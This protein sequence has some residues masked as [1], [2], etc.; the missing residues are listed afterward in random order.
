MSRA[1]CGLRSIIVAP[2]LASNDLPRVR[3]RRY[4]RSPGLDPARPG[5]RREA[6]IMQNARIPHGYTNVTP[7]LVVP[8]VGRQLD[9]LRETF[10]AEV[11]VEPL[12]RPDGTVMHAEARIGNARVMMG[13][14]N[15]EFG[16]VPAMLYV[17]V[18]DADARYARALAAGGTSLVEPA[19]QDHGDRYGGVLDPNGN[20]WFLAHPL[21]DVSADDRAGTDEEEE[22]GE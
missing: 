22:T 9:F 3:V 6:T 15:A 5:P 13:E 21:G 19:D 10:D 18:D 20:Q 1:W 7:Y 16:P 17:Y 14:S 12:R 2:M 4:T 11:T 8:D